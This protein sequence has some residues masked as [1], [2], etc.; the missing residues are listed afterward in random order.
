MKCRNVN[1]LKKMTSSE[2]TCLA[3]TLFKL[4]KFY[5]NL[6]TIA[7]SGEET[8]I[9]D[10]LR[11]LASLVNNSERKKHVLIEYKLNRVFIKLNIMKHMKKINVNLEIIKE[12]N[13]LGIIAKLGVLGVDNYKIRDNCDCL[14]NIHHSFSNLSYVILMKKIIKSND[15]KLILSLS[16]FG[17]FDKILD[18]ELTSECIYYNR[19]FVWKYLKLLHLVIKNLTISLKSGE[20]KDLNIDFSICLSTLLKYILTFITD[21]DSGVEN[22]IKKQLNYEILSKYSVLYIQT[23]NLEKDKTICESKIDMLK[24]TLHVNSI[25]SFDFIFKCEDGTIIEYLNECL[26]LSNKLLPNKILKDLDAN[27]LFLKLLA[28]IKFDYQVFIDWLISNETN[29][30]EYFL[31]YLKFSVKYNQTDLLFEGISQDFI[32]FCKYINVT[33]PKNEKNKNY[34]SREFLKEKYINFLKEL[35]TKLNLLK[36]VFPY[37]CKPLL[38]LLKVYLD[39][40]VK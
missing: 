7:N 8:S 39:F 18:F 6:E 16:R 12:T 29:F 19:Y 28:S 9:E 4:N 23:L 1:Y 33:L 27:Y 17:L 2:S 32:L 37:N 25:P 14:V 31:F 35:N 11:Y 24:S 3:Q 22:P 20:L 40:F 34:E 38:N 5:N 36:S 21:N 30:L 15:F 13:D 26:K 10:D